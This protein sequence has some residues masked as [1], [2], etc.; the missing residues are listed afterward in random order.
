MVAKMQ[1]GVP[2]LVA[3]LQSPRDLAHRDGFVEL[4]DVREVEDPAAGE[5]GEVGQERPIERGLVH[6]APRRLDAERGRRDADARA[7]IDRRRRDDPERIGARPARPGT[8][9]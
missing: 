2:E 4:A 1:R 7:G 6:L 5:P 9:P 3:G 8:S